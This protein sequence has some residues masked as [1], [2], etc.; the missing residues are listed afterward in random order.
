MIQVSYMSLFTDYIQLDCVIPDAEEI[1]MGR[2][3]SA[4]RQAQITE[5]EKAPFL[6]RNFN[7]KSDRIL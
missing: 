3:I 2:V 4:L 6:G 7:L 5:K 1:S